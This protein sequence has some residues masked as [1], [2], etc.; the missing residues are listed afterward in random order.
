MEREEINQHDD[1]AVVVKKNGDTTCT[2]L[3][4]HVARSISRKYDEAEAV[5]DT[6]M[7]RPLF[8]TCMAF[9]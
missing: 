4:G 3:V 5:P 1:Y 2:C 8:E 9:V 7:T 6:L